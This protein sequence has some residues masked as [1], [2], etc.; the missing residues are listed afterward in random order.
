MKKNAFLAVALA[1][2]LTFPCAAAAAE[3]FQGPQGA[4][5]FQGPTSAVTVDTVAKAQKSQDETPVTLTGTILERIAGGDDKYTFRDSSGQIVVEID[6]ELFL[7]RS[8]T[9]QTKVRLYG[10]VDKEMMKTT[11]IDVK[12]LDIL[13]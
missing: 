8:V 11:K 6:E 5:G 12:R 13:Q 3:G 2:L 4:G 10:K 1:S 9:P 7:G